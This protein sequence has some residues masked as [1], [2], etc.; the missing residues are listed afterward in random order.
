[1][2]IDEA[3]SVNAKSQLITYDFSAPRVSMHEFRHKTRQVNLSQN[4]NK[5]S[6]TKEIRIES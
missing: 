1:M 2:L 3:Q 4:E 5:I 6:F